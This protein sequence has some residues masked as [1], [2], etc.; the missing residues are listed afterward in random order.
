MNNSFQLFLRHTPTRRELY[1][2]PSV[3][4]LDG[5]LVSRAVSLFFT[6]FRASVDDHKAF[7]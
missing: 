5:R 6:A 3:V 2:Q 1:E 4:G 7:F